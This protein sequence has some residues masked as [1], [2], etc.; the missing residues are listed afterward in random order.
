[1]DTALRREQ[2]ALI[3][4]QGDHWFWHSGRPF[5]VEFYRSQ[6]PTGWPSKRSELLTFR[7]IGR[8]QGFLKRFVG[9]VSRLRSARFP[10]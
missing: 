10:K 8:R 7:T 9:A 2:L 3:P 4:A 1:V 5:R 6:E